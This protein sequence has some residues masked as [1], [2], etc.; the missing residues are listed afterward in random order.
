RAHVREG[1]ELGKKVAPIMERGD[2]V[3]DELILAIIK[4][5]L[6]KL[7]T[8]RVIFDGFPRTRAQAEALDRLLEELGLKLNAVVLLE[9]PTEELVQRLL[10]R[11]RE[12]GRADDNEE[13]IR[14]RL[15]VY[16]K[17]TEPLVDYYARR[18]VLFTLQ[19]TGP[20][21]EITEC[22]LK[23]LGAA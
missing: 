20:I 1:T 18:G 16:Q 22:I 15:L 12:E 4:E 3:P 2:L 5:E 7:P 11:A 6:K 19:G 14:R 21:E 23:V 9:V 10:K 8:P 13:T 17:E